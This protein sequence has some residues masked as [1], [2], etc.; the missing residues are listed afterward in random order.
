[1]HWRQRKERAG[2]GAFSGLSAVVVG[3]PP[4]PLDAGKCGL[5]IR[6]EASLTRYRRLLV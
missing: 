1:M 5:L 2:C 4:A 6:R 3:K